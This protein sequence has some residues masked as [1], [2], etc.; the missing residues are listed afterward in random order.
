MKSKEIFGKEVQKLSQLPSLELLRKYLLFRVTC[1]LVSIIDRVPKKR[2][3][4]AC[5]ARLPTVRRLP[6]PIHW[7]SKH[8]F[9]HWEGE[10]VD[11]AS[12][13]NHPGLCHRVTAYDVK[14]THSSIFARPP[15]KFPTTV[16]F[17]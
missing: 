2:T 7:R 11:G 3:W 17:H 1:P 16:P 4:I 6:G 10:A 14:R 8:R 15:R 5:L 9:C 12:E 13:S